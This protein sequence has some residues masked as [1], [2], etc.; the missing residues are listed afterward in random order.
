M[1]IGQPVFYGSC[2]LTALVS[3]L[4]MLI[5]HK[6]CEV[7][8]VQSEVPEE[9]LEEDSSSFILCQSYPAHVSLAHLLACFLFPYF[10]WTPGSVSRKQQNCN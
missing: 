4:C 7:K 3:V 2:S 10:D 8:E 6:E 1:K 5:T 9:E